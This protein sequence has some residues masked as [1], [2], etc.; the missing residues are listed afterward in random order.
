MEGIAVTFANYHHQHCDSDVE[1]RV[2]DGPVLCIRCV[3]CHARLE[4]TFDENDE[5][6]FRKCLGLIGTAL[7]QNHLLN[8]IT[9]DATV[10]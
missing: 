10:Q 4:I 1:L 7:A 8:H 5:R 6:F 3:A 9:Q 2:V